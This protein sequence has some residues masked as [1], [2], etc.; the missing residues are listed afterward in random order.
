MQSIFIINMNERRENKLKNTAGF[1]QPD[2]SILM[3][4]VQ[5]NHNFGAV[6]R[7]AD[8]VGVSAVYMLHH[9]GLVNHN[10]PFVLGKRSS[11]GTRKWVDVNF[12]NDF[13]ATIQYLKQR[14]MRIYAAAP[15]VPGA[16][17]LYDLDLTQ[18]FVFA[19]GNESEGLSASLIDIADQVY[20]IPQFGMAESLNVSV[21]AA[22]SLYEAMRQRQ[23]N[24]FYNPDYQPWIEYR[25]IMA[26]KYL[27]L[28]TSHEYP[29]NVSPIH[30]DDSAL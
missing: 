11:M 16:V 17:S 12:Y 20:F 29:K 14:Y 7:S 18:P 1:R 8:A 22:I 13:D 23:L 6:L 3:E 28:G 25:K 9:G 19:M 10:E 21:A 2:F 5:D 30:P 26:D 24:G 27:G 4:N 15:H